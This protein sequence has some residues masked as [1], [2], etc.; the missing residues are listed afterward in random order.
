MNPRSLEEEY[1]RMLMDEVMRQQQAQLDSILGKRRDNGNEIYFILGSR[2]IQT[3]PDDGD[4]QDLQLGLHCDWP[5][6]IDS[7]LMGA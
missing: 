7:R 6:F 1:Q 4:W 2:S 3:S 5:T